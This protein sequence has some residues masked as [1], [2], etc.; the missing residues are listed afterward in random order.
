MTKLNKEEDG[1]SGVEPL[2]KVTA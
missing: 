2:I 1:V